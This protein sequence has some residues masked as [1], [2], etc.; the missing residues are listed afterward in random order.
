[1]RATGQVVRTTTVPGQ[2]MEDPLWDRTGRFSDSRP[3]RWESQGISFKE[4][5]VSEGLASGHT[6]AAEKPEQTGGQKSW[7]QIW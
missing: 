1:M 4:K 7:D 2:R 3:K 6:A 5:V